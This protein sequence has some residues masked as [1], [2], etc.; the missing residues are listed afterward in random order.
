[1]T[2]GKIENLQSLSVVIP[3]YNEES[4]LAEIVGKLLQIPELLEIIIVDD[5]STDRSAEVARS[6]S[7]ADSRV[8][9]A[10]QKKNSGKTAA[11]SRS[12]RT[13]PCFPA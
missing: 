8:Q 12:C 11:S 1:M 9:L 10:R 6:L 7:E 4:S 3:V 2:T 5:C 13:I